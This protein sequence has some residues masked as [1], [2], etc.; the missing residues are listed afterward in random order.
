MREYE[1]KNWRCP[2]CG[3]HWRTMAGDVPTSCPKCGF[4]ENKEE[5]KKEE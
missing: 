1:S 3:H 4:V 2:E 5:I